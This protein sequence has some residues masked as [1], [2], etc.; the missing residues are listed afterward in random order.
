MKIFILLF[1]LTLLINFAH[2]EDYT[3]TFCNGVSGKKISVLSNKNLEIINSP[4]VFDEYQTVS[5]FELIDETAT[6]FSIIA[7]IMSINDYMLTKIQKSIPAV[8]GGV[9]YRYYQVQPLSRDPLS[10]YSHIRLIF[11]EIIVETADG[12]LLNIEKQILTGS[13][14]ILGSANLCKRLRK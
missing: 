10:L 5:T 13:Y 7:P 8:T 2:A 14:K 12:D 11:S 9:L 6:R 3:Q 4:S 1:S